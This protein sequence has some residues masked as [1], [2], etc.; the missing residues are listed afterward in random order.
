MS[1]MLEKISCVYEIL[2]TSNNKRYIGSTIDFSKRIK[3]HMKSLWKGNHHSIRLQ[4]SFDKYGETSF[5]VNILREVAPADLLPEEQYFIDEFRSYDPSLGFNICRVAGNT[6]G[7]SHSEESR[8]KMSESRLKLFIGPNSE[9]IRKSMSEAQRGKSASDEARLKMSI[10][11]KGRK[12]PPTEKF[13]LGAIKSAIARADLTP[14]QIH[15]I[16]S[17]PYVRGIYAKF[18]RDFGV[19]PVTIHRVVKG[20]GVAYSL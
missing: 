13:K 12:A 19:D 20:I 6:L 1:N 15:T 9:G 3:N 10:S 2:N 7:F 17:T 8:Q 4:R 5:T 14:E 16:R 18:A 11:R